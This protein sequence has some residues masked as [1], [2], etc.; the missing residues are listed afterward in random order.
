M[1]VD[2]I[3]GVWRLEKGDLANERFSNLFEPDDAFD[4]KSKKDSD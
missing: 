1:C 4:E 2:F 3:Y